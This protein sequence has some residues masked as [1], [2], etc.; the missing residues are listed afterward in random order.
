MGMHAVALKN[1]SNS[2][3]EYMKECRRKNRFS[4]IIQSNLR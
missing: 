1:G 3:L 4:I 2:S